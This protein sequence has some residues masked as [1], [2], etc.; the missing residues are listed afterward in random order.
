MAHRWATGEELADTGGV[1][2]EATEHVIQ[3]V[4]APNSNDEAIPDE[5]DVDGLQPD[6]EGER[7]HGIGQDGLQPIDADRVHCM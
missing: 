6:V 5:V 7:G 4:V 2:T 1:L 3:D